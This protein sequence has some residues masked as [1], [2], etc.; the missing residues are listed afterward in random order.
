MRQS[1]VTLLLA[2]KPHEHSSIGVRPTV[3]EYYPRRTGF[4]SASLAISPI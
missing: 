1:L 3:V 4:Q 2:H